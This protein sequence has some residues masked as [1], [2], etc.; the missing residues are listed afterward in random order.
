[1]DAL[2]FTAVGPDRPGLV[3]DLT[4]LVHQAG[5]NL[6]DS[7]MVN[8]R[9]RFA[10]LMLI[11]GTAEVLAVLREQLPKKSDALGLHGTFARSAIGEK[12]QTGVPYRLKTY[13]VDQPGIVARVSELLRSHGINIEE[14]ETRLESAPFAGT[15]L[16]TLMLRMTVPTSLP[17]RALRADLARLADGLNCDIDID[18]V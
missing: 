1:M 15:P 13:S 9:G 18:P 14:L 5:A 8:L 12:A 10:L 17:I 4:G 3:G 6:A 16:F 11:E 7:R 2:L